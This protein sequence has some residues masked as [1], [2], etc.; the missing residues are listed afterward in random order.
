M[1]KGTTIQEFTTKYGLK[2]DKVKTLLE[3]AGIAYNASH[4]LTGK[5][6][7][8]LVAALAT[9]NKKVKSTTT[10]SKTVVS[11]IKSTSN[12]AV[13]IVT[14]RKIVRKS[15]S[16]LL[17][18]KKAKEAAL[19][20]EE[21]AKKLDEDKISAEAKEEK[22]IVKA[23]DVSKVDAKIEEPKAAEKVVEPLVVSETV[24]T[25][26]PE[27]KKVVENRVD[28]K[29]EKDKK[30]KNKK[31]ELNK[32][33][34][35]YEKKYKK[36]LS[37]D[38]GVASV[39]VKKRRKDKGSED[40]NEHAFEKPVAPQVREVELPET[41][42]VSELAKKMSVKAV[43]LIKTMMKLGAMA[44]INQVIDQETA[45]IIV[46]EMG[47]VA[48]PLKDN[49]VED[50]IP[51]VE[52]E[53]APRAPVVTIM[54]HVDHGKTSLLDYIRKTK[55]AAGEAGGITQHIGAYHVETPRGMVTFLDTPG[56][57]AFTSMRSRGARATDVVIIVVAADD[58]VMPQTIEAIS[59]SK[60]AGVPIVVAVNKID[61]DETDIERINNEMSH[62]GVITEAW[63]GDT[64]FIPVSAK[65]GQGVDDLLE[66]VLLQAEV[67]ELTAVTDCPATGVVVESRLDK[68]R[69]PVSTILVQNGH[70]SVGDIV[71]SGM[72]Y[73]KVRAMLD[74]CGKQL[75][76]AGPSLPVEVLGLSGTAV[77]GD[78]VVVV[79]S[80]RKA[81][82]I[83][84][85][86]QGKFKEVKLARQQATKLEGFLNRM[87][88]GEVSS[89]NIVLKADTQGSVE[90]LADVLAKLST[91]EVKVRLIASGV[92]GIN[93]S[94][95][96]LAI[97]SSGI[98]IGFNVRADATAR[99]SAEKEG[100]QLNYYSVIYDIVDD[101]KSAVKGIAGPK[102]KEQILGLAKVRDVFRS[103]KWG[104]IAGCIVLEG[105]IK[106]TKP[107]RVLRDNVVIYEGEL[108]S[109]RRFKDD[110]NEVK[111]GT[112]CGIGV[113]DYNDIKSGD[114]IEVFDKIMVED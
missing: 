37:G 107:I 45:T 71:V 102:Y 83:T 53:T 91:D 97:A 10:S 73:G 65:T 1:T 33:K 88:E 59:H 114:E 103:S 72:Q 14:K 4:V 24:N 30:A 35:K 86:R 38:D 75:K 40:I 89:L 63:G 67:L 84:L 87:Q 112:E 94:D 48:K 106:R 113:K 95:V 77:S 64:P 92:G 61:K 96:S 93:E 15:P 76:T 31:S 9:T 5:E 28:S 36:Y 110:V 74:E 52:G 39:R 18:E 32:T 82:E 22:T 12:K 99:Q 20:K 104:A 60:A 21:D 54:G 49:H 43:D 25:K 79:E 58:G 7:Q 56:H 69:G 80:E 27:V 3:K 11:T 17:Q 111:S 46:E 34:D 98:L 23:Q 6:K 109:L 57:A 81:R 108:E 41:I 85:F 50:S 68:G 55:V 62:H 51:T 44:T 101:V 13:K 90:A 105:T 16:L 47:H 2:E 70:L 29:K 78:A 66:S 26:K 42:V 19:K 100:V 8:L